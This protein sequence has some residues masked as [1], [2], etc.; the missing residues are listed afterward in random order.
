M[1]PIFRVQTIAT[2]QRPDLRG[3][4]LHGIFSRRETALNQLRGSAILYP[5]DLKHYTIATR[6]RVYSEGYLVRF[7]EHNKKKGAEAPWGHIM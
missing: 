6:S 3:A 2:V 5:V 4:V 1:I 7:R